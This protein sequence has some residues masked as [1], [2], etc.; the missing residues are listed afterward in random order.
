MIRFDFW[1]DFILRTEFHILECRKFIAPCKTYSPKRLVCNY[2][3][4]FYF[5]GNRT[6]ILDDITYLIKE[7]SVCFRRPGQIGSSIGDYYSYVLTLD[8][9]KKAPLKNYIRNTASFCEPSCDNFLINDLPV[10][11]EPRNFSDI[12]ALFSA[13]SKQTDLNCE[14]SYYLAKELL[15]LLNSDLCHDMFSKKTAVSS[16]VEDIAQYLKKNFSDNTVSLSCL[17]ER[18]HMSPSYLI[19][20]FKKYYAITPIDFLINQRLD[21]AR[22]LLSNTD[23]NI[24]EIA[25]ECGYSSESFFSKQFK[26][27]FKQTPTQYRSIRKVL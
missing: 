23:M 14:S 6:L 15:F 16:P 8:F 7:G 27:H 4:D 1:E 26:D 25:L 5:Q 20:E 21:Y 19:R 13:L 12:L 22:M 17:A 10:V 3:L 24:S 9:S 11:F 2:E 18:A